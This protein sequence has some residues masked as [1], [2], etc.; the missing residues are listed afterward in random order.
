MPRRCSTNSERNRRTVEHLWRAKNSTRGRRLTEIRERR[1]VEGFDTLDMRDGTTHLGTPNPSASYCSAK[2]NP[3]K[4]AHGAKA[5][6]QLAGNLEFLDRPPLKWGGILKFE[7][8]VT[9]VHIYPAYRTERHHM[10]N[11]R[12]RA[13]RSSLLRKLLP[14][15]PP[16]AFSS[17]RTASF[18]LR[19]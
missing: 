4:L 15:F 19:A 10:P 14:S 5:M 1:F 6:F 12:I 11:Q 13:H 8:S 2:P 7:R 3:D 18:C 16:S 9:R 17:L